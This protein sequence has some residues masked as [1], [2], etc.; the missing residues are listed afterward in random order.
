MVVLCSF[1]E[2]INIQLQLENDTIADHVI[3]Y[4]HQ[5]RLIR[6][7][8]RQK[9]EQMRALEIERQRVVDRY[10]ATLI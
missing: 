10:A 4:Q 2:H 7:R 5:R 1:A 3:L 9:D 6:E 8:L